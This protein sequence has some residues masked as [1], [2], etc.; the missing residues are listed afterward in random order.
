LNL[1]HLD[2]DIVSDFDIR[3]SSLCEISST[4]VENVRQ[5]STFYAKQTQSQVHQNQPKLLY[6]KYIRKCG[7]LVIQTNKAKTNPIKA[8]SNPIQSQLKPK[9][10]QFKP[11]L[12]QNQSKKDFRDFFEKLPVIV[13]TNSGK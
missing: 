3:I 13:L 11:N 7:Q 1:C 8:N 9:Q 2:F 12:S 5:I 10:T 4:T 6:D